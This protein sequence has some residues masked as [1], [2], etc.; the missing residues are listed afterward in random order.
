VACGDALFENPAAE[1]PLVADCFL[2]VGG[3]LRSELA[4]GRL[5][6]LIRI[7][8]GAALFGSGATFGCTRAAELCMNNSISS[9][10]RFFV[11]DLSRTGC[12]ACCFRCSCPAPAK[13]STNAVPQAPLCLTLSILRS[14]LSECPSKRR[15]FIMSLRFFVF[16]F[17]CCSGRCSTS[18]HRAQCGPPALGTV[19]QTQHARNG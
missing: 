18:L 3:C 9:V 16:L 13:Y 11:L 6:H 4:F 19:M 7:S 5:G 17:R 1:A 12:V 15:A 10:G 2:R 8:L 14:Q